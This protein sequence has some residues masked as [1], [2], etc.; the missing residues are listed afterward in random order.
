MDLFYSTTLMF[1]VF[2]IL[3][4][5]SIAG[6]CSG[7]LLRYDLYVQCLYEFGRKFNGRITHFVQDLI[8]GM[9]C[10]LNVFMMTPEGWRK[11]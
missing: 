7:S 8:Y 3:A 4:V 10:M 5:S 6:L 9:T 2:V 11:P 1:N